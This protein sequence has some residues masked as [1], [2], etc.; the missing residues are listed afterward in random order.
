MNWEISSRWQVNAAH[1]YDL[2]DEHIV[3]NLVGI[4][5]ESCCWGLRLSTKERYLSSTQ[6]DRGIYLELVLKG[7]GGFGFKQ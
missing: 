2:K 5:Y 3:E 4:N 6:T 1:L 7:L